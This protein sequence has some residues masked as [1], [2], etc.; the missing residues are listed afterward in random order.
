V[1]SAIAKH[2]LANYLVASYNPKMGGGSDLLKC[3]DQALCCERWQAPLA[4]ALGVTEDQTAR[5]WISAKFSYPRVIRDRLFLMLC[6][7]KANV[8]KVISLVERNINGQS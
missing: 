3:A 6:Y 1:W 8:G 7:Q 5:N 2:T 4:R